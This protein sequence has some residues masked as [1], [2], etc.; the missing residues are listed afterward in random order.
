[1]EYEV[2]NICTGKIKTEIFG[3]NRPKKTAVSKYPIQ[4]PTFLSFLGLEGD[5]HAYQGHGGPNKAICLY[6]K[7]DY[8]MWRPY[9]QDMPEYAMFGENITTIGL[10]KDQ[11]A[12]GDQFKFGEAVIQITEGRGPCNT[13]AKKYDVP[14]LVKLMS[15]AHATGCYFR[16]LQ[17]G[18]VTPDSRLELL[19][20]HP[21]QFTLNAFNALKYTDKKNKALLEKALTVDALPE[22]HQL[23]FTKQLQKLTGRI[24]Y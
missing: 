7:L 21:A 18:I 3:S 1:M 23:K 14:D 15:A 24:N 9:I 10:T 5:E 11:L 19:E 4:Q 12:I 16:V 2:I 6:D 20:K 17:E 22:E 8:D 13:I